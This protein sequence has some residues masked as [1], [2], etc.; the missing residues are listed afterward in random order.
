MLMSVVSAL[1]LVGVLYSH[2]FTYNHHVPAYMSITPLYLP[3][4]HYCIVLFS[5]NIYNYNYIVS[6]SLSIMYYIYNY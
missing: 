4:P 2:R 3:F 5:L 6:Y 1:G